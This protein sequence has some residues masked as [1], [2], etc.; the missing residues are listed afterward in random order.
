MKTRL[1]AAVLLLGAAPA[2]AHR[3]D[4]YLQ[5]TLFSVGKT[6]LQAE[7]TLTPGVAVFPIVA[8]DIDTNGDGVFSESE[9]RAYAGRVLRD[10]SLTLDGHPLTLR[11][12]SMRFPGMDQIKAGLGAIRIEFQAVLPGGG[13][14]RRLVFEN[15]HQSRLGAY[16][17]N[18]LVP[19]DPE[20]QIVA[21]NRNYSQS[22]YR[23]D[24][25]QTGV[26]AGIQSFAWRSA[27][28]LWLG[29]VALLVVRAFRP[30]SLLRP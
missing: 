29:G 2:L 4:E 1:I 8:A 9:Q 26:G 19:Q 12:L 16:L 21:Q 20:I 23:L 25:V 15:R 3:L 17:V 22:V 27:D 14:R 30:S 10:L 13:S 18:C 7:I 11:L 6:R 24:Y 28:G 5:E